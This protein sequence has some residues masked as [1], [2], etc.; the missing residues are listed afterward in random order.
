MLKGHR[1]GAC[2]AAWSGDGRLSVT[3]GYDN[4]VRLW[5]VESG[6]M[7]KTFEGPT[8][9]VRTVALSSDGRR[10]IGAGDDR[11]VRVWDVGTGREQLLAGHTGS[12]QACAISLDGRLAVSGGTDRGLIAWCLSPDVEVPVI[13]A[14]PGRH[15]AVS[16]DGRMVTF[17]AL[18]NTPSNND[19]RIITLFDTVAGLPLFSGDVLARQQHDKQVVLTRADD[20]S[21]IGTFVISQTSEFQAPRKVSVNSDNGLVFHSDK[22]DVT[23]TV[24]HDGPVNSVRSSA[25]ARQ[26]V[27]ASFD[28]TLRLW[29]TTTGAMVASYKG[30]TNSVMDATFSPDASVVASGSCDGS[31]RLWNVKNARE[32]RAFTRQNSNSKPNNLDSNTVTSVNFSPDGHVLFVSYQ[33]GDTEVWDFGRPSRCR[34][35]AGGVDHARSES[36]RNPKDPSSLR[37]GRMV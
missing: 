18:V 16:T 28:Q 29:D 21:V 26:A 17:D 5:D 19:H 32:I 30:H 9:A 4:T 7:V 34:D 22:G 15:V 10:V 27:S 23:S 11:S 31:F 36:R 24:D 8:A 37:A 1:R 6:S 33:A 25:D 12:V 35:L 14:G 13:R 2:D 3:A 20:G